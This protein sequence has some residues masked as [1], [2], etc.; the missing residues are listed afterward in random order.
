[1]INGSDGRRRW[2]RETVGQAATQLHNGEADAAVGTLAELTSGGGEVAV[3]D[4]R[5]ATS[6]LNGAAAEMISA[7]CRDTGGVS[8]FGVHLADED[9]EEVSI[10]DIVPPIRAGIRA[11]L[12]DVNGD[13]ETAEFQLDL[14]FR[15][16]DPMTAGTVALHSLLWASD[17]VEQCEREHIRVPSWLAGSSP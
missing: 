4:C 9:G 7:L 5:A 11:L 3:A 1:V 14:A 15:T 13:R 12:A 16:S 6:M 2:V 17:L 8:A 10:D